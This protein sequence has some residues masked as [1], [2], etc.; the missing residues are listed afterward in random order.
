MTQQMLSIR[1]QPFDYQV[2]KDL[3]SDYRYPRNKIS[4]MLDKGEIIALKSGLY[5][6]SSLYGRIP[7]PELVANLLYGPSYVSLDY[8]LARYGLIP[9]RVFT[10]TSVCTGRKKQFDTA[11]GCFSYQQLKPA[12]YCLAYQ[13]QQ[14]GDSSYLIA[15]PE[16]ALCDKLYLAARVPDVQAMETFLNED[17]RIDDGGLA[18]LD[19]KLIRQL[20]FASGSHNLKLLK[21]M[22]S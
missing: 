20:A 1:H 2:L 3:L 8:A 9:E 14:A 5:V 17:L 16:K 6:L 18:R 12:Y 11:I 19:R 13:R 10:V 21:E 15:T 7:V 4:S 22:L